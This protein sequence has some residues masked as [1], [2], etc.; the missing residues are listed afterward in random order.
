MR[1]L[2]LKFRAHVDEV[3][4]IDLLDFNK[5]IFKHI[6]LHLFKT[7]NILPFFVA[8]GV[9]G[10]SVIVQESRFIFIPQ[11]S[12]AAFASF[13][14]FALIVSIIILVIYPL[15]IIFLVNFLTS[16]LKAPT[17]T[18]LI[19]KF[20]ILLA[21]YVVGI[22]AFTNS[23]VIPREKIQIVLI[24]IGLYFV[25]TGLYLTHLKHHDLSKLTKTKIGFILLV[26]LTMGSP[27]VLI[28]MHISEALNVTNIN[29]QVYLNANNCQLL[30]NLNGKNRV[31]ES[32]N[33]LY[34]PHYF[35][36]LPNSQGCYI[37]GNTIRYGFAYDFVLLVKKNI[38][39]LV[40]PHGVKYNEYVRLSC[41]AGNC[42]SENHI[43]FKNKDD[44]YANLISKGS[45]FDQPL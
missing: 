33:I 38:A 43:F 42:Y 6:L 39:P 41:Y 18:K 14:I 7:D 21:A 26:A 37:Y 1:K 8:I 40:S 5:F 28:F 11:S 34:D 20:A 3:R 13:F 22:I 29:T 25:L 10:F 17:Y 36:L 24:W 23:S 9:I 27:L 15:F 2:Y 35:E 4:Q 31:S 32:N 30:N 12:V 45:K 44:I 19:I 16:H